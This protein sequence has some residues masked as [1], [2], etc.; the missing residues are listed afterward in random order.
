MIPPKQVTSFFICPHLFAQTP[1]VCVR[2]PLAERLQLS[3]V[4]VGLSGPGES[5]G[6]PAPELKE[7]LRD[8]HGAETD[9]AGLRSRISSYTY[10]IIPS[11]R[12]GLVMHQKNT[13]TC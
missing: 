3:E 1:V 13:H 8:K 9:S 6:R 7:Q 2:L 11:S 10:Y 12:A 4:T 5:A